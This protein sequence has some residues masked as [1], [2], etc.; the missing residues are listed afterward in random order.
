M[1]KRRDVGSVDEEVL[2]CI[3]AHAPNDIH[4]ATGKTAGLFRKVSDPDSSY[5]LHFI[6]AVRLAA[7]DMRHGREPR[8]L[9]CMERLARAHAE[10]L[11]GAVPSSA[12][13]GR[14]VH[15]AGAELGQVHSAILEM[16]ADGCRHA[17]ELHIVKRQTADV[18]RMCERIQQ[19]CD[20]DLAVHRRLHSV[21][22][23]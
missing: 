8:L 23:E 6:D 16:D 18:Q 1:T 15:H 10:D 4:E 20:R 7:L 9:I 13:L 12:D 14:L 11:G 17:E 19:A 3:N 5:Q 21:A 22:A 2:A